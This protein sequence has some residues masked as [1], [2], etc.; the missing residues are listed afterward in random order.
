MISTDKQLL[1][2]EM[3]FTYLHKESYW[4]KGISREIFETSVENTAFCF[5]VYQE[6]IDQMT[7]QQ[8]GFARVI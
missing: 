1:D 7:F 5:G 6:E 2:K 3:I 4:S 8:V